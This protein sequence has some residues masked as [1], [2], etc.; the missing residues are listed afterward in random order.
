VDNL[1]GIALQVA[2]GH[3]AEF[4]GNA[5]VGVA[6]ELDVGAAAGHVGGDGD[7]AG[8]AGLGYDV[9]FLLVIAGVEHVEVAMPFPQ[10]SGENFRFLDR[11]GADQNRLLRSRA[12][13][14]SSTMAWYF[15]STVR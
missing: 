6:A 15:S 14:M 7:R 4:L 1:G 2:V 8:H 9:G 12:S 13:L 5:H 11:G 10:E 3:V